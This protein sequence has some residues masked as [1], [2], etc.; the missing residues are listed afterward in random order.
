MYYLNIIILSFN[1]MQIRRFREKSF[2]RLQKYLLILASN[3]LSFA[4]NLIRASQLII[5]QKFPALI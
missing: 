5:N 4:I 1:V 3:L 2:V